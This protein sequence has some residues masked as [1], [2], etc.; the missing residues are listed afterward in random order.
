MTLFAVTN[1]QIVAEM[2]H[3]AAGAGGLCGYHSAKE[4]SLWR[5]MGERQR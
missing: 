4:A 1:L 2:F 3:K 5:R